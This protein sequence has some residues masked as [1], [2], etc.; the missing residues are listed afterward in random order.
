MNYSARVPTIHIGTI[1]PPK[2]REIMAYSPTSKLVINDEDWGKQSEV[3]A[4][5]RKQQMT[6]NTCTNIQNHRNNKQNS[7][8]EEKMRS[9]SHYYKSNPYQMV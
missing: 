3:A 5:K 1:P 2:R 4:K 8:T 6:S 9:N 7:I